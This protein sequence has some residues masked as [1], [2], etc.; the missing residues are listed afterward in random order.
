[1]TN[2]PVILRNEIVQIIFYELREWTQIQEELESFFPFI[3]LKL[4]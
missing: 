4:K 2:F 3:L 1:M